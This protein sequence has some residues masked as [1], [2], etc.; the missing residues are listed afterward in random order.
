MLKNLVNAGACGSTA[1]HDF[2]TGTARR[3]ARPGPAGTAHG[4]DSLTSARRQVR[5][6]PPRRTA[7]R[8]SG[9]LVSSRLFS[10]GDW[11]GGGVPIVGVGASG[12]HHEVLAVLPNP[13]L[14][15]DSTA[16]SEIVVPPAGAVAP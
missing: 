16:F 8:P 12:S 14:G 13:S 3:N 9:G 2:G 10:T 5:T 11:P 4:L 15:A 6:L 7:P 1:T